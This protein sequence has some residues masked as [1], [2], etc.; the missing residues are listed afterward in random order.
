MLE[1][2]EDRIHKKCIEWIPQQWY[3]ANVSRK[4]KKILF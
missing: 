3:Y 1:R 4:R 2:N